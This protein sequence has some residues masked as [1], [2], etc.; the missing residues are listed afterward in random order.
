MRYIYK[1][2]NLTFGSD[3]GLTKACEEKHPD[4]PCL[5]FM[6]PH[7]QDVIKTPF[8]MFNSKYDAWQLGSEFQSVGVVCLPPSLPP[9]S[10]VSVPDPLQSSDLL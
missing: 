4:E 6:S 8:F 1:M 5:C 3:G 10:S 9:P 2:Q 7:M